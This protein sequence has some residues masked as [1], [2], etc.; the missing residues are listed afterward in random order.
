MDIKEKKGGKFVSK[1]EGTRVQK[2][3]ETYAHVI[4]IFEY[5]Y[6]AKENET[7]YKGLK[8]NIL[9]PKKIFNVMYNNSFL[10]NNCNIKKNKQPRKEIKDEKRSF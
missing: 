9:F 8:R 7:A 4:S 10:G 1:L 5:D 2:T 3:K 6:S